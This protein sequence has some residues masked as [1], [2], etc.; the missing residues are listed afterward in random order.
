MKKEAHLEFG[1]DKM[2]NLI[3]NIFKYVCG[4][5]CVHVCLQVCMCVCERVCTSMQECSISD[6][7]T[8]VLLRHR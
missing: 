6:V 1:P 8:C 4:C 2:Y 7:L 3:E 5:V